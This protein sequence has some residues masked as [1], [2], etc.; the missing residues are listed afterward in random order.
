MRWRSL[1]LSSRQL[2]RALL[3]PSY[4]NTFLFRLGITFHSP[5]YTTNYRGTNS[6][7]LTPTVS[8]KGHGDVA[9]PAYNASYGST[10]K[11]FRITTVHRCQANTDAENELTRRTGIGNE[12]FMS[13]KRGILQITCD[14]LCIK[15]WVFIS[16]LSICCSPKVEIQPHIVLPPPPLL[17]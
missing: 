5:K 17:I 13:V 9:P 1:Q 8:A 15:V 14:D 4:P 16:L 6:F 12:M 3:F 10:L 7:Q 11:S 2:A